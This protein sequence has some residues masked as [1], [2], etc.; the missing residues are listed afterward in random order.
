[1]Q[2]RREELKSTHNGNNFFSP[3]AQYIAT[4]TLE[5]AGKYLHYL[6]SISS[7]NVGTPLIV[8][9]ERG[10]VMGWLALPLR[11]AQKSEIDSLPIVL[12]VA[13]EEDLMQIERNQEKESQAYKICALLIRQRS[14]EMKL[15][16]AQYM[17]DVNKVIFYFT[18]EGRVDFRNLV[19]DLANEL[20]Y[21]IEMRQIGV[22]DETKTLSG[23]G[24]CGRE[25][26]CSTWLRNFVP[27]SIRMAKDQNLSLNPQKVSGAC[28]RL[29]CCL[30]YEHQTYVEHKKNL[31]KIGT[32]LRTVSGIGKVTH[33]DI[34]REKV[35]LEMESGGHQ[36]LPVS[37]ILPSDDLPQT[38][39][40]EACSNDATD[41]TTS[42]EI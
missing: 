24:H 37:E 1:M 9:T 28:G 2:N 39:T 14:L 10:P 7:L 38:E 32:R 11:P 17:L 36:S 42:F 16:K 34:L 29:L 21:R 33:L 8:E 20:R 31:P 22:R 18:A 27:V 30:T 13:N 15:I 40:K 35:I 23:V 26:C 25:L 5:P 6:A 19:K 3:Q 4:V 41:E 12:R